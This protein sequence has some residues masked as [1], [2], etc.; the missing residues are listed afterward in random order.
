MHL[1]SNTLPCVRRTRG[2]AR[3]GARPPGRWVRGKVTLSACGGGG[4]RGETVLSTRSK[5]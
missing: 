2:M 4:V 3:E 5:E 1:A